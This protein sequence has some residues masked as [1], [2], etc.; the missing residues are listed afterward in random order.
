MDFTFNEEQ[1]ILRD[2]ARR[3]VE[4]ECGLDYVKHFGDGEKAFTDEMW[5]KI[6]A[7]GWTAALIPEEYDGLGLSFVDLGVIL[8]EMGKGPMP[9]PFISTVVLA[10]ETIRLAGDPEQKEIYLPELAAGAR[11]GT[12]AW[13]EPDDLNNLDNLS[14]TAHKKGES[15]ILNGTKVFV[16]DADLAHT[17][18]CVA[19]NEQG[20]SLFLVDRNDPGV[21]VNALVT[22][23]RTTKLCEVTF[24]NV[25]VQTD[26]LLANAEEAHI[27]LGQTLNRVNVAYAMDMVG[28]GQR[29]LDIGVDYAKTR[30]QFG[31]PIGSFQAI[32]HKCAELLM[33]V[34]CARSIAYYAAWALEQDEKEATINAS[35]AKAFCSEMYRK[36]TKEVLQILGGIGFSWEHELHIYLKRAK[37]LEALFGDAAFH[38][39]RLAQELGY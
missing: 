15:F 32:K 38:R 31:Q 16:P 37:C 12:L 10:G 30:V 23:D 20:P 5:Q 36:A 7:L 27:R 4:N 1:D 25:K 18:I 6:A 13:A 9:G 3:F 26:A 28:G 14:L 39:E 11:K 2:S 8:E 29:V 33:E 21:Q 22:M 19:K 24:N 34:E 35:V 17:I